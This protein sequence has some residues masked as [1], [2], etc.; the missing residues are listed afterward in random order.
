MPFLYT[1]LSSICNAT[2]TCEMSFLSLMFLC[3]W[4]DYL[5]YVTCL[6]YIHVFLL[7][8]TR[9]PHVKCLSYLLCFCVYDMIASYMWYKKDMSHVIYERNVFLI[10]VTRL[11]D[12]FDITQQ[13][14]CEIS[15][16][17]ISID[18][19]LLYPYICDMTL[20]YK[21]GST[22]LYRWHHSAATLWGE[23][24]YYIYE[25]VT[26]YVTRLVL[27]YMWQDSFI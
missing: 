4:H 25:S 14:R 22:S 12:T 2:P 26:I 18:S 17:L 6:S 9:L 13:R 3:V 1:C 21:R 8:V 23:L 15:R 10:Y 16:V 7:Y 20:A 5:I 27:S 24:S 19:W 11:P